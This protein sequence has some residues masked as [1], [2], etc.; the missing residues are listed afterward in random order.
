VY[1]VWSFVRIK[2]GLAQFE[3]RE[4]FTTESEKAEALN[5]ARRAV[6]TIRL[7]QPMAHV[8]LFRFGPSER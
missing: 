6:P 3:D 5:R 7:C 1:C 2:S 4:V 8:F